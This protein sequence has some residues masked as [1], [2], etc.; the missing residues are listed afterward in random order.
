MANKEKVKEVKTSPDADCL[1]FRKYKT[2]EGAPQDKSYIKC[3]NS[4]EDAA[5]AELNKKPSQ[6]RFEPGVYSFK[7]V[8]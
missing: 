2:G 1:F 3:F 7:L 8:K 4:Y 6:Y 5:K